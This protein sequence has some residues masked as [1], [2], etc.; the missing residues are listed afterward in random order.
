MTSDVTTPHSKGKR[1]RRR[2][3][4]PAPSRIELEDRR[5]NRRLTVISLV[6]LLL[7]AVGLWWDETRPKTEEPQA[8]AP[9]KVALLDPE[10]VEQ[11]PA[12]EQEV[13]EEGEAPVAESRPLVR[14]RQRSGAR[15]DLPTI[16]AS[17]DEV[18][19]P[20][21]DG[22]DVGSSDGELQPEVAAVMAPPAPPAPP[23]V[24]SPVR[25]RTTPTVAKAPVRSIVRPVKAAKRVSV[26]QPK[27]RP[28]P[29]RKKPAKKQVVIVRPSSENVLII[30][31]EPGD[32]HEVSAK[33]VIE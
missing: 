7:A 8:Q 33:P 26:K 3:Y 6:V 2:P 22:H 13:P 18:Y 24:A 9:M 5:S 27:R 25:A 19:L 10:P 4:K 15:R 32:L 17:R 21:E 31:S 30:G 23:A 28:P 16:T 11:E 1:R 29:P 20:D 14:Q 12:V